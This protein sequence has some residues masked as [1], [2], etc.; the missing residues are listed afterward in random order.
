M[1]SVL[2]SLFLVMLNITLLS[3]FYILEKKKKS[4][5]VKTATLAM[6]HR[7][8]ADHIGGEPRMAATT[9]RKN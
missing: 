6:F 5:D 4:E 8:H 2:V 1:S 9:S 7:L 3:I